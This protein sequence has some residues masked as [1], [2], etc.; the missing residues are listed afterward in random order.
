M[1]FANGSPVV[2]HVG[3]NRFPAVADP[4]TQNEGPIKELAAG[5]WI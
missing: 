4:Q 5:I 2:S 3:A 1:A